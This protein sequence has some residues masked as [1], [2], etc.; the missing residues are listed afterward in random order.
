[1]SGNFVHGDGR[2]YCVVVL[3]LSHPHVN[4]IRSCVS[5]TSALSHLNLIL[6]LSRI[7]SEC[8]SPS[9][10]FVRCSSLWKRLVFGGSNAITS[11]S[12]NV[13]MAGTRT[14][15]LRR[16]DTPTSRLDCDWES[17][18]TGRALYGRSRTRN[19]YYATSQQVAQ[20]TAS[21]TSLHPISQSSVLPLYLAQLKVINVIASDNQAS[22]ELKA[23]ALC[24]NGKPFRHFVCPVIL[25]LHLLRPGLLFDNEYAWN[26]IVNEGKTVKAR[27]V[28][29]LTILLFPR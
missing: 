17:E 3:V 5:Y 21:C 26:I 6:I 4:M 12:I 28:S 14:R 11:D 19:C 9:K 24:N 15:I 1:M 18:S 8:H 2:I 22:V 16:L 23:N 29:E 13:P 7:L 20:R 25:S 10:V 27:S